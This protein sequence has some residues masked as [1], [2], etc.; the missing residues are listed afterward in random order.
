MS[1]PCAHHQLCAEFSIGL[2]TKRKF[3][4]V[5]KMQHKMWRKYEEELPSVNRERIMHTPWCTGHNVWHIY[6]VALSSNGNQ[7][8]KVRACANCAQNVTGTQLCG[9]FAFIPIRPLDHHK[10]YGRPENEKKKPFEVAVEH[11]LRFSSDLQQPISIRHFSS[12][13]P[14]QFS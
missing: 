10:L 1:L 4:G 6:D 8:G 14:L 13:V 7:C 9:R 11:S 3:T 12:S 2:A 5:V